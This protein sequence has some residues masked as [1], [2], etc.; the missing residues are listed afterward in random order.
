MGEQTDRRWIILAV[1]AVIAVGVVAAIL[2]SRSGG[3]RQ[4]LDAATAAGADGCKQVEA[5][6]PKQV[7]L[8]GAEADREE[9]RRS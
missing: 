7:C 2:I 6:E 5:P 1:F 3:E 8:P 4:R 9:G